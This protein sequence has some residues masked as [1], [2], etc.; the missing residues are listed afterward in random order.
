[1][2]SSEAGVALAKL[3]RSL[4]DAYA[5]SSENVIRYAASVNTAADLTLAVKVLGDQEKPASFAAAPIRP[6][7]G[8][9]LDNGAAG[10]PAS[11]QEALPAKL[12]AIEADPRPSPL[13]STF[14]AEA[15]P[16]QKAI[17]VVRDGEVILSDDL[18]RDYLIRI[19]RGTLLKAEDE[20]LLATLADVGVLA[21]ERLE[22][23]NPLPRADRRR[24]EE[25]VVRGAVAFDAMV[26][27]NLR[28]VVSIAKQYVNQGLEMADLIQEG[29]AGLIKAVQKFDPNM[30]FK[31]STYATWWVKQGITRSIANQGRMIRLPVYM[32]EQNRK[33]R[34]VA[35]DLESQGVQVSAELIARH[36]DMP[37]TRVREIMGASTDV[38]SYDAELGTEDVFALVELLTREQNVG[39]IY[40]WD[41]G[42]RGI[43]TDILGGTLL[44]LSDNER[45]VIVLRF[46]LDGVEGRTLDE[47]GRTMGLTRER[48]RQIESKAKSKLRVMLADD[49]S[50]P[51]AS[52][53]DGSLLPSVLRGQP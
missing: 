41:T 39:P 23:G 44:S 32:H 22:A 25:L 24:F 6:V 20:V 3:M 50:V 37:V 11:E 34:R 28:L 18:V 1:M 49:F 19:G 8:D 46:G 45:S 42:Y 21:R 40:D 26:L 29:S 12:D 36:A 31:F 38:L 17:S 47:I 30:G 7:D 4:A 33:L 14:V 52:Y 15:L 43:T 51:A 9:E 27:S 35:A 13:S 10:M 2:G 5:V 53:E 48:I 16:S